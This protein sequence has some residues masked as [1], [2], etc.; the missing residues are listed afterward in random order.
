VLLP[1]SAT[2]EVAASAPAIR[3][4]PQLPLKLHEAPDPGAVGAEIGLDLGGQLADGGQVDAEQLAHRSSGA[5]SG[6]PRSGSCQVSTEPEYRTQVRVHQL[7]P[8][9]V[10]SGCQ[11]R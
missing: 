7:A 6:R 10:G 9:V 5:A 2:V 1:R 8:D 4:W 11:H 3:L